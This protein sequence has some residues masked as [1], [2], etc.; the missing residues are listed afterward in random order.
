MRSFTCLIM[1]ACAILLGKRCQETVAPT[2]T[3]PQ[4]LSIQLSLSGGLSYY[5]I[6]NSNTCWK[7]FFFSYS[8]R[9]MLLI[10]YCFL[11]SFLPDIELGS[12]PLSGL[13]ARFK[14][15]MLVSEM[16]VQGLGDRSQP[17]IHGFKRVKIMHNN[18]TTQCTFHMSSK[19]L[20]A[21]RKRL[22]LA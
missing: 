18:L 17:C 19:F 5:G 16:E 6:V 22:W 21:H 12:R 13:W 3:F 14:I 15:N 2:W 1:K 10:L 20:F 4:W 7:E 11:F 9:H 8:Q